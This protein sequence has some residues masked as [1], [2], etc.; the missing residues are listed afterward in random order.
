MHEGTPIVKRS[1]ILKVN[2]AFEFCSMEEDDILT[3]SML[4]SQTLS[5]VCK[6]WE[7][8]RKSNLKDNF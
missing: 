1:R 4:I 5:T 6:T 7:D 2:N 8:I 3:I